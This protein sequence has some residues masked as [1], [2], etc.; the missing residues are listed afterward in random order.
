[1]PPVPPSSE[2]FL[3]VIAPDG[4]RN[5]VRINESPFLI[6]RGGETGNHLNLNDRRI[7]RVGIAIVRR[8]NQY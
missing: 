5:V 4:S 6:G 8:G 1:M 7:S 3:E 2:A